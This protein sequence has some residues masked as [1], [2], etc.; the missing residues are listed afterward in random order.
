MEAPPVQESVSGLNRG[1]GDG[2][3]TGQL[4]R[5]FR[6]FIILV[7]LGSVL[8]PL[9]TYL[10]NPGEALHSPGESYLRLGVY[11]AAALAM[12]V[13]LYLLLRKLESHLLKHSLDQAEFL[14]NI[15]ERFL[16]AAIAASASLSLSLELAV[17]RSQGTTFAALRVWVWAMRCHAAKTGY[18]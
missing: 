16:S 12:L 13:A 1:N 3:G 4:L 11:G 2:A 18:R 10:S 6:H 14:E 7:F 9:L 5:S 17:I 15:P 8:L